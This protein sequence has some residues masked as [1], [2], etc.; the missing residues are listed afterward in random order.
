MRKVCQYMNNSLLLFY[1]KANSDGTQFCKLIGACPLGSFYSGLRLTIR[2]SWIEYEKE[3]I[4]VFTLRVKKE[5]EI[6]DLFSDYFDDD[7]SE[8]EH[9]S[10]PS[11]MPISVARPIFFKTLMQ[12]A[13]SGWNSVMKWMRTTVGSNVRGKGCCGFLQDS[14]KVEGSLR[15][16]FRGRRPYRMK[17]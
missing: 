8:S 2:F 13:R 14:E 5:S 10:E 15:R 12:I 16:L 9:D 4:N 3:N 7:S 6:T 1:R 11:G 17:Q